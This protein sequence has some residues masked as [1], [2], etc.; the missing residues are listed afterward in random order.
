MPRNNA[1]DAQAVINALRE[2][3]STAHYELAIASARLA[4]YEAQ[5]Q[6]TETGQA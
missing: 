6:T 5:Q 3:L 2:Q 1:V 4:E